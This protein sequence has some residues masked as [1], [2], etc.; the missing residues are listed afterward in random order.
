LF[1]LSDEAFERY[2]RQLEEEFGLW[3]GYAKGFQ[4]TACWCCPFQTKQQY[5]TIKK[6]LPFLWAVLERKAKEWEF[7]GETSLEKYIRD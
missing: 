6:E 2:K 3:E 4:R 7:Q 5:E 1:D